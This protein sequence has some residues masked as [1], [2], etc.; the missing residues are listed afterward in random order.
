MADSL[1]G[2]SESDTTLCWCGHP[3]HRHEWCSP[4]FPSICTHAAPLP[5][6][7]EDR[8]PREFVCACFEFEAEK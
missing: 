2:R 7:A 6:D 1:C 8:D 3:R 5:A 4:E